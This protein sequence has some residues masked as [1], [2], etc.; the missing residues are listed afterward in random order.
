[1]RQLSLTG[2]LHF[3]GMAGKAIRLLPQSTLQGKWDTH[4]GFRSEDL[5]ANGA[6]ISC[7]GNLRDFSMERLGSEGVSSL[8]VNLDRAVFRG[9]RL[10]YSGQ[11]DP[12][13][14]NLKA[15]EGRSGFR[16]KTPKGAKG[17][18]KTR[19]L[20]S[21]LEGTISPSGTVHMESSHPLASAPFAVL[22]GGGVLRRSDGLTTPIQQGLI[23]LFSVD[24]SPFKDRWRFQG[25]LQADHENRPADYLQADRDQ[26]LSWSGEPQKISA[27]LSLHDWEIDR[28]GALIFNEGELLGRSV[29]RREVSSPSLFPQEAASLPTVLPPPLQIE[30][31]REDPAESPLLPALRQILGSFVASIDQINR[32]QVDLPQNPTETEIPLWGD[33]L[34]VSFRFPQKISWKMEMG[35]WPDRRTGEEK[36]AFFSVGPQRPI[37]ACLNLF[38]RCITEE[39]VVFEGIRLHT[40]ELPPEQFDWT[41]F[42]WSEPQGYK[43]GELI[44]RLSHGGGLVNLVKLLFESQGLDPASFGVKQDG[45]SWRLPLDWDQIRKL[46]GAI[47]NRS[48]DNGA[49][50]SSRPTGLP[51]KI[52]NTP[53]FLWDEMTGVIDL[54]FQGGPR[55]F[56]LEG[57]GKVRTDLLFEMDSK[58]P[59]RI[60]R[61]E[62][63]GKIGADPFHLPHIRLS[64]SPFLLELKDF[65]V[66]EKSRFVI[67][68]G[69]RKLH[70]PYHLDSLQFRFKPSEGS[71]TWDGAV[72]SLVGRNLTFNKGNE[73]DQLD[74]MQRRFETSTIGSDELRFD[75]SLQKACE[76]SAVRCKT[77]RFE[78]SPRISRIFSLKQFPH[79]LEIGFGK[80]EDRQMSFV[81]GHFVIPRLHYRANR[82]GMISVPLGSGGIFDQDFY[83]SLPELTFS[84][85][86]TMELEKGLTLRLRETSYARGVNIQARNDEVQFSGDEVHLAFDRMTLDFLKSLGLPHLEATLQTADFDGFLAQS[87]ARNRDI[88]LQG[89]MRFSS[90]GHLTLHHHHPSIDVDHLESDFSLKLDALRR[91]QTT[92]GDLSL[93]EF[94]GLTLKVADLHA[95][96]ALLGIFETHLAH[97]LNH[98]H[99]H[100]EGELMIRKGRIRI[101]KIP[102]QTTP[103]VSVELNGISLN[104][105]GTSYETTLQLGGKGS[106]VG[107][108]FPDIQFNLSGQGAVVFTNE[109]GVWRR[110]ITL[111]PSELYLLFQGGRMRR[112]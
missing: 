101:Q 48:D 6:L 65:Q 42:Q 33:N 36:V 30:T 76:E 75:F 37:R 100:F 69:R 19:L 31:K 62:R 8:R 3:D 63:D 40:E 95:Q 57:A 5:L 18:F 13:R 104:Q 16:F 89:R 17:D 15:L 41:R 21:Q 1:S 25:L 72:T 66:G 44:L 9:A 7:R 102:G 55:E 29:D 34:T 92:E 61:N 59:L 103:T 51:A 64:A 53:S 73:T 110:Q 98:R 14:F 23:N 83:L 12:L 47:L 90:K 86:G 46:I 85:G 78:G 93:L 88:D 70:A 80:L 99:P 81:G 108:E 2:G 35:T 28:K 94:E 54:Q 38:G 43:P 91:L 27:T 68:L 32:L 60:W 112:K 97:E 87:T 45:T 79:R 50:G 107:L 105:N 4:C 106:S 52:R 56:R 96:L 22:E 58:A 67:D 84:A 20:V 74:P 49:S 24:Y 109:G 77:A 111:G 10:Y 39:E 82:G 71:P 26:V 11:Q